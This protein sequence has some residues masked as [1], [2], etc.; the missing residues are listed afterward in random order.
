[1]KQLMAARSLSYG[2]LPPFFSFFSFFFFL[3]LAS[4]F[5]FCVQNWR[6][7]K[8]FSER[9]KKGV[10][11]KEGRPSIRQGR[12]ELAKETKGE[13]SSHMQAVCGEGCGE[14]GARSA[15]KTM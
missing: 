15:E 1:M 14:A 11:E 2:N 9:L 4:C 5:F 10:L 6:S 12:G 3:L 8:G 7:E 13:I